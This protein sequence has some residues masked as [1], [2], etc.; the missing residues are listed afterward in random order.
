M[1]QSQSQSQSDEKR[2]AIVITAKKHHTVAA[3][4]YD[5][6][7]ATALMGMINRPTEGLDNIMVTVSNRKNGM[8]AIVPLS[9]AAKLLGLDLPKPQNGS[10]PL[11]NPAAAPETKTDDS[12]KA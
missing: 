9:V 6:E 12:P 4:V 5:I 8:T 1:P 7:V 2:S 3:I 11:A 10:Q